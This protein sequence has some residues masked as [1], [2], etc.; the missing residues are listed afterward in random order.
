MAE[1]GLGALGALA[2]A[3]AGGAAAL[4]L[5]GLGRLAV[6]AE[7]DLLVVDGD[8]LTD[9][10]VLVRPDRFRLVIQAGRVVAGRDLD[11]PRIGPSLNT[12]V[13]G[14][15]EP[16]TGPPSPCLHPRGHVG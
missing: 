4:G 9:V 6:G 12:V 8:P 5:P 7:A 3:T 2:A 11:G 16:P 10:R 15:P 13:P 14:D 1:G